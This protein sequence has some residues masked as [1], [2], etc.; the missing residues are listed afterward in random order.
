MSD[1]PCRGMD[2]ILCLSAG[3]GC[4]GRRLR[5]IGSVGASGVRVWRRRRWKDFHSIWTS[6]FELWH[7]PSSAGVLTISSRGPEAIRQGDRRKRTGGIRAV[8]LR[9]MR[10]SAVGCLGQ[11]L[12]LCSPG[13]IGRSTRPSLRC[14]ACMAA[15]MVLGWLGDISLLAPN[16]SL[17]L[18]PGRC[19]RIDLTC[20]SRLR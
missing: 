8:A 9:L 17:I 15:H 10:M 12:D 4:A 19:W 13:W 6:G 18:H 1:I 11:V 14:K 16:H 7:L 2:A 5:G 3:G 20:S